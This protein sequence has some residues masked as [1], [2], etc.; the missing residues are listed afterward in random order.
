MS[1]QILIAI[2]QTLRV[3]L[4]QLFVGHSFLCGLGKQAR[5][6][7]LLFHYDRKIQVNEN[8]TVD[9]WDDRLLLLWEFLRVNGFLELYFFNVLLTVVIW[10]LIL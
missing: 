8:V 2:T 5:D 7:R 3:Q 1:N 9:V 6:L 4:R 10:I